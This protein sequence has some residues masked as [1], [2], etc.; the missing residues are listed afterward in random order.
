M[1]SLILYL[2]IFLAGLTYPQT[3]DTITYQW[4]YAPMNLQRE[5][6]GTFGEYRS[7]SV[8]GHYHNG[9]DVPAAA[10]TPVLAV[11]DGTVIV[12]YDDGATGY[13]SYVRIGSTINGQT[14]YLTY[15]HTR[16][17]VTV[18][19]NVVKG[20]MISR[21]A[22]DHV[23]II[24]YRI[25]GGISTS[26]INSIRPGGGLTP[27]VDI[28]KPRIR[29]VKF[30]VDNSSTQLSPSS[31]GGKVD[32]IVHVE[33]QNG[34]ASSSMNNGTYE[35]GYQILS[36]D[37]HSV[38]YNPPDNGS[39]YRYYNIP[40]NNYVNINYY[41]PE[42]ST[43]QHVYNVTNGTGASAVASTQ[44]VTN[45]YFNAAIFPFGNYIAK[46]FTRDS[47]GNSDS[48]LIPIT[49]SEIDQ[50]PTA[51]PVLK[52]IKRDTTN[53]FS[54]CWSA[55]PD[56]DLKGYR[57]YYSTDGANYLLRDGENVLKKNV[58]T[59]R[60]SYS[61][62][63]PLYLKLVA[64]D[65]N[66]IPN[67]SLQ[68]DVYGLKMS[69]TGNRVLLVDGFDRYG[70]GGNWNKSYHDFIIRYS[71]VLPVGYDCAHHS[72]V[73]SDLINLNNYSAVFWMCGDNA[74]PYNNLD[75]LSQIRIKE[76]LMSGGKLFISGSEIAW[77]LVAS[78][79]ASSADSAFL[80]DALKSRFVNNDANSVSVLG[81]PGS[82]AAGQSV[83]FGLTSQGSPYIEDAPDII[84]TLNGSDFVFKYSEAN[85]AGVF[86][87][88]N[89]FGSQTSGQLIYLAFPFEAI[90][91]ETQR[92][93][94]MT[95]VLNYFGIISSESEAY[96]VNDP[97]T[98]GIISVYPNPA[99][100]SFSIDVIISEPDNSVLK[101]YSLLGE[102]ALTVSLSNLKTGF[103]RIPVVI[104]S[105]TGLSS[106]VYICTLRSP[107]SIYS[108]KFVVAK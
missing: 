73:S 99:I 89:F 94:L 1:K 31:I 29:Y 6:T 37:S 78:E 30:L 9:T 34:L 71:E 35:I 11:L 54:M 47:R 3:A 96:K 106:G 14:K 67:V 86:Y 81:M 80:R 60:Y 56:S 24:D 28:W 84:D 79:A 104:P 83:Q 17:E 33:E 4:P 2:A 53:Y 26:H 25:G 55:P 43:S 57:L 12:A 75:S 40:G 10:Y 36:A 70:S 102:E 100:G 16:P 39:R 63:Q 48:V 97:D 27:Y 38:V 98:E 108:K 69:A 91:F 85:G 32:I 65:T 50:I 107:S 76:Y 64:I 19:Q 8:E 21:V 41:Q 23:H 51:A 92:D 68:S 88:G 105:G 52:Y 22:I 42:S 74:H 77:D 66:Y 90:G 82:F 44:V 15:Y 62:T 46:I 13:D 103:N 49:I 72:A 58:T 20:Q 95:S 61:Q 18:G 7:T 93:A 5:V 87:S 101:I 45:N 59:V